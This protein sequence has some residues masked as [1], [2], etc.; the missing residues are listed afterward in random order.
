VMDGDELTLS[1]S[2]HE[3]WIEGSSLHKR[4]NALRTT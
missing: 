1:L 4:G 3:D 2:I